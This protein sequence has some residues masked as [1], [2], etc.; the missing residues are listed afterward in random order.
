MSANTKKRI[1]ALQAPAPCAHRGAPTG[2][3]DECVTCTGRVEL[4][5]LHCAK[6]G[7]CFTGNY[8]LTGVK[9][10]DRCPDRTTAIIPGMLDPLVGGWRPPGQWC[11]DPAEVERHAAAARR[12]ATGAVPDPPPADGTAVVTCGGGKYWPGIVVMVRM[13]REA[14]CTL[15]V[16][17]WYR[18]SCETVNPTDVMGLGVELIDADELAAARGDNRVPRGRSSVGGWEAKLYALTH[19]RRRHVAFIDADAYFLTDPGRLLD[20][21]REHGFAA[22]QEGDNVKWP[23]CGFPEGK[24]AAA[25][26]GIQGGQFALD[27]VRVWKELLLAHWI[28]QHSDYYWPNGR[29]AGGWPLFGDQDA[30][31]LA[32][33]LTGF[34]P[35]IIGRS[36]YRAGFGYVCWLDGVV[37]VEHRC[38]S[39]LIPAATVGEARALRH[40]A[41]FLGAGE[42]TGWLTPAEATLLRESCRGRRVLEWGRFM[43]RST[44]VIAGA[45]SACWS[46]DRLPAAPA[47]A[48]LARFGLA[49]AAHLVVGD[50]T[51]PATLPPWSPDVVF[52]DGEHH[53]EA[54]R[55]DLASA[56]A[57]LAPGG[58]IALHDHG[59]PNAPDVAPAADAWAR[60][61]G[62]R[63]T[64]KAGTLA[65]FSRP[66]PAGGGI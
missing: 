22:W 56:A 41:E 20:L 44:V 39:K 30:W 65:V 9:S 10:C 53:A 42:P 48:E 23:R 55:R 38:F 21:G 6:H 52:V 36:E 12:L 16:E 4:P 25:P 7:E 66:A 58:L 27:R 5:I 49:D 31:R 34:R 37:A 3:T 64:A 61:G 26:D 19:T 17:V 57:L 1:A 18:G 40:F 62:W 33:Q 43:G 15:P 46:V 32:F 54:V 24:P 47:A 28:C 2:E 8:T 35:H 11:D 60:A 29:P 59:E 13:L 14:G 51:D 63:L 50:Y 45:A